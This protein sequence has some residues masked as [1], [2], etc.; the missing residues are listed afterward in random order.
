MGGMLLFFLYL[1][2]ICYICVGTLMLF[3]P[4]FLRKKLLIKIKNIP[5]KKIGV[6]PIV[7][8]I[9]LLLSAS[10]MTRYAPLVVILGLL[11]VA[12]GIVCI[13]APEK[14]EKIREWFVNEANKNAYRIFGALLIIIGSVVLTG[15]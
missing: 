11:A 6:V 8:G 10:N 7:V 14:M 12:K 2:G 3:V 9:L 15:I 13:V 1:V 4:E 5:V